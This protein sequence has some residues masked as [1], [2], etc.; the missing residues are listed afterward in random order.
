MKYY[1]VPKH[2]DGKQICTSKKGYFT[3]V[4]NK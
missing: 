1:K 4:A 2:L 3:F